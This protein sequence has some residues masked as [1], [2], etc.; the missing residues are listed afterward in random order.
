M[1]SSDYPPVQNP[2][3]GRVFAVYQL[4]TV[5]EIADTTIHEKQ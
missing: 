5:N 1:T 3:E 4:L 2:S